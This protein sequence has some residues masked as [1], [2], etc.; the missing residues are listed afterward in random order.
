MIL[1]KNAFGFRE[2]DRIG[3][4]KRSAVPACARYAARYESGTTFGAM[5][6]SEK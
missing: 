5:T 1:F 2:G 3:R 6:P 4:N